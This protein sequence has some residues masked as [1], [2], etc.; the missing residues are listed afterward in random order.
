MGRPRGGGDPAG[1]PA[2]G[3][4]SL[5]RR[6]NLGQCQTLLF[7]ATQMSLTFGTPEAYRDAVRRVKRRGLMFTA[8]APED[9]GAPVLRVEGV[10]S[11][12]RSTERYGTRLA[13]IL[14]DLLSLPGWTLLAKVLYP[15]LDGEKAA[16][17]LP[18]RPRDGGVPRRSSRGGGRARVPA[19]AGSGGRVGGA[20]RARSGPS[21]GAPTSWEGGSSIR[22]SSCPGR[23]RASTWKQWATGRGSGWSASSSGPSGPPA[24]TWW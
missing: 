17:R 12:L 15:G 19:G 4:G 22:T 11:F 18:S 5:L 23:G 6:F 7:K 10:V 13:Q 16:P 2:D 9:G 24:R 3:P 20:G 14:P 1:G 21:P 8:E